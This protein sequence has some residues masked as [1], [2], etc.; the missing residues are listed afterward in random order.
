MRDDVTVRGLFEGLFGHRELCNLL[1]WPPDLFALTSAVL[2]QS[3]AYHAVVSPPRLPTAPTSFSRRIGVPLVGF[4]Q[5]P[6]R[7]ARA[8]MVVIDWNNVSEAHTGLET[9]LHGRVIRRYQNKARHFARALKQDDAAG[10]CSRKAA[11]R[12]HGLAENPS[13]PLESAPSDW[14][15]Q[16]EESSVNWLLLLAETA[17]EIAGPVG[18]EPSAERFIA[19]AR[20]RLS[21][22]FTEC[23]LLTCAWLSLWQLADSET[24]SARG[25][26]EFQDLDENPADNSEESRERKQRAAIGLYSI[27]T[28]HAIADEVCACW[29]I[30]TTLPDERF[31]P[32]WSHKATDGR[33]LLKIAAGLLVERGSLSTISETTGRVLPK[34]HNPSVG[35]ALR[36]VSNS[37]AFHRSSVQVIWQQSPR[38]DLSE[39]VD[40]KRSLSVLILPWPL[41]VPTNSFSEKLWA[42]GHEPVSTSAAYGYFSYY[43]YGRREPQPD[44]AGFLSEVGTIIA[45]AK[46][47]I[48][49]V[50][51]LI[52]PE[53]AIHRS[54]QAQ[55]EGVLQ[56]YGVSGYVAGFVDPPPLG[57]SNANRF[58]RNGLLVRFAS[59]VTGTKTSHFSQ[60]ETEACVQHK[61]HR[62]K[63]TRSQ[64][65]TYGL[66]VPL[67][68][69]RDWWEA[70]KIARRSV[71]FFNIGESITACALICEDLARQDP[72]ADLIRNVG[73][74]MVVAIL[75]D[76]P[77]LISRWPGRYAS[78]LAEDPGSSVLTLTSY[79]MVTRWNPTYGCDADRQIVALWH[80]SQGRPREIPLKHGS[81]G[82]LLSLSPVDR[83]EVTADGRKEKVQTT[84]LTLSGILQVGF[85]GKT[86]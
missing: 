76:G 55:L 21:T 31:L 12:H 83:R 41:V 52:L 1:C 60:N 71:A 11:K 45:E 7:L 22:I 35:I 47:D 36:S 46:R 24:K 86:R 16:V 56:G 74:S 4:S 25:I 27:L 8:G 73:P 61:H 23:E 19:S 51:M 50:D 78:V 26:L 68:P 77:Q 84:A 20:E 32:D 37:I 44:C 15:R 38:S 62:W 66:G 85:P 39:K 34:R 81:A 65:E 43:P 49:S 75:L 3:G 80:D 14:E 79:G 2:S 33:A 17:K 6:P 48:G 28:L 10:S 40:A 59:H 72:I 63:L 29:G 69:T 18:A 53:S 13:V 9:A 82:I 67:S 57:P 54:W 30:R 70:M 58:A 42:R 5:W 64:I